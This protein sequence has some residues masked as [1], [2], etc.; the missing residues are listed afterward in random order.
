MNK[1]GSMGM[2]SSSHKS[3]RK[4]LIVRVDRTGAFEV[5]TRALLESGVMTRQFAA[6]RKLF[7]TLNPEVATDFEEGEVESPQATTA[8]AK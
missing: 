7:R 5:D 2:S 1:Y 6:A 8:S 4:P 3:R